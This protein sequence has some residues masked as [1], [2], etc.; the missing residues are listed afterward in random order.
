MKALAIRAFE[1]GFQSLDE[2][3]VDSLDSFQNEVGGYIELVPYPGRNDVTVYINE[4]GKLIG[5]PANVIATVILK[6][7]LDDIIVGN[8]V[9]CGFDPETGETTDIPEDLFDHLVDNALLALTDD[10]T[11]Q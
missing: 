1:D 4:E 7:R 5:L 3:E 6:P 9:I 2:I 11:K 10:L 8:A